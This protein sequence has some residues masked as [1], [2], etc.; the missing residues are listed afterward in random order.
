MKSSEYTALAELYI[1]CMYDAE[2]FV[3]DKVVD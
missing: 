1:A 2:W 3:Y